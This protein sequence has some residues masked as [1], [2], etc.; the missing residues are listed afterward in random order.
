[1]GLQQKIQWNFRGVAT[2]DVT[3]AV[4]CKVLFEACSLL[5]DEILSTDDE[6]HFGS[7]DFTSQIFS[8]TKQMN[9]S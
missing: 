2:G 1:M 5:K 6:N 3:D 4:V 8:R 9:N 7:L